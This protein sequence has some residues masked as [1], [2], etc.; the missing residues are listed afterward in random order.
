MQTAAE[1][2]GQSYRLHVVEGSEDVLG[3][4]LFNETVQVI[5]AE[6]PVD[7]PCATLLPCQELGTEWEWEESPEVTLVVVDSIEEATTLFNQHS[8]RLVASLISP[9]EGTGAVLAA[10]S[11]TF[12]G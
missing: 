9:D 11:L 2:R 12:C 1:N 8:P 3:T 10:G 7:E 5:R 4:A 6:G